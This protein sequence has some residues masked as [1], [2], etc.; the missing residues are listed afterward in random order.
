MPDKETPGVEMPCMA[1]E[2]ILEGD[3]VVNIKGDHRVGAGGL[4]YLS[5]VTRGNRITRL[6][7]AVLTR[8]GK[9]RDHR[10]DALGAALPQCA[11]EEQQPH[12][13]V[14]HALLRPSMQALN[15]IGV[16]ASH[17]DKRPPLVLAILKLPLFVRTERYAH[18]VC[19]A[20]AEGFGGVESE[21]FHGWLA[22]RSQTRSCPP[23]PGRALICLKRWRDSG[24]S[25][26]LCALMITPATNSA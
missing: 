10:R 19:N 5:Q 1:A 4:K 12:E 2:R 22:I 11:N 15:H 26:Q 13:L 21:E 20:F 23:R 24:Q 25:G 6:G 16:T 18:I 8:I 14:V 7:L 9:I 3:D 17:T